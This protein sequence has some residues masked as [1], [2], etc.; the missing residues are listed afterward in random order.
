M[1]VFCCKSLILQQNSYLCNTQDLKLPLTTKEILDKIPIPPL[2]D[3][4][5]I[6][7]KWYR[8]KSYYH[9]LETAQQTNNAVETLEL[10]NRQLTY[11]EDCHSGIE[12][13]EMPGLKY[14]GRM[15]PIM[16]DNIER[17]QDGRIIELTKGNRIIIEPNG[18]FT[19]MT[20]EDEQILLEKNMETNLHQKVIGLINSKIKLVK[21]L[22]VERFKDKWLIDLVLN[23]TMLN[24][25][26]NGNIVVD[27][28]NSVN[29]HVL[30]FYKNEKVFD[31]Y[32]GFEIFLNTIIKGYTEKTHGLYV[33][34]KNI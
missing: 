22:R 30:D 28:D 9:I 17:K 24:I 3:C 33:K 19:I 8:L 25:A 32:M 31:S 20:R 34:Y 2:Y 26:V 13:E 12:P 11:V 5:K 18:A 1:Q 15:Y 27:I 6:L 16:E 23:N 10:I 4:G 14:K 7:D 29:K 21:K